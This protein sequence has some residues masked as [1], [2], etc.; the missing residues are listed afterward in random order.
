MQFRNLGR[1]LVAVA[2]LVGAN[3]TLP[4]RARAFDVFWLPTGSAN[5]NDINNWAD[6]EGGIPRG[7][8]P[9]GAFEDAA[10]INNGGTATLSTAVAEAPGG[11]TLGQAAANS[12]ALTISAGGVMTSIVGATVNGNVVVGQAGT[13][14]LNITGNG[15]LT[16]PGFSVG[17]NAA[18]Q[19]NFSGTANVS[20]TG[21]STIG[22]G[23]RIT[24]PGVNF[25]S[26]TSAT[27]QNTS[28][29]T[30]EVTSATSHS[31]VK[32]AGSVAL[33]GT[34]NVQFNGVTP[35]AG[36]YWNLVDAAAINGNF[37]NA[38]VGADLTIPGVPTPAFG[39]AYRLRRT[40]GGMNGQ[41][42]QVGLE[43]M[44][45]L[46]V[47]RDTGEITI[48]NPQGAAVTQLTGY[49]ITSPTGGSLLAGYKGISG[50]PAGNAGWE[51]APG[52]STT[53]LAEFKPTGAFDVSSAATSVS[54]GTAFSKTAVASKGLGVSGE[55]LVF[56]Y[57][58]FGGQV[59][60]GQ[61]EYIGTP[62]LNNISLIVNTTSGQ[63][64]LK[65]DTLQSLAIDG[66]SIVSTTGALSGA[67]WTTLASRP[68][69]FPNWQ[70]SPAATNALS[71]TNSVG[72]LTLTAGQSIPLG[73]IGNFSSAAAQAGLGLKFILGNEE[74]FRLGTISLT[75][76]GTGQAGDF[77]ADGDVDGRDFLVW[78]R[79]GSPAPLSSG[80]LAAW[81][82]NFGAGGAEASLAAVPEPGTFALAVV[83]STAFAIRR[84]KERTPHPHSS[85]TF[86]GDPARIF[87]GQQ[88]MI[89]K[90]LLTVFVLVLAVRSAA[91][92]TPSLGLKFAATDPDAATSSL[93]P[94]EV[95]GVYPAPN[96][97]NLSGPTGMD[98]SGHSYT[99]ATGGAVG[100]SAVV[101]WSSPNTW[102]S[103]TG[104]NA[105]P[106]GPNRKLTAGYLDTN[107]T[108]D[109]TGIASVTVTG[110]DAAVRTPKYDVFVYFVS[111]SGDNRGG[112][113]TINDGSGPIVK[114]GSTM[115]SPTDFVEDPGTD[116]NNSI[117][118]TFLRFSGL[119]GSSFTLTGN[120]TLTTPNG[121]RAPINAVQ[122]VAWTGDADNDG[123]ADINDYQV[124]R[125]N[126]EKATSGRFA[127]G[128]L[129]G[130][131]FVD[132]NDFRRWAN[133]APPAVVAS[134]NIP[135]P[136][137]V[138]MVFGAA[139]LV[140]RRAR[141][142]ACRRRPTG[143]VLAGAALSIALAGAPSGRAAVTMSFGTVAPTPGTHDQFQLLDDQEVPG[144][145][146]PGGGT[147][148]S[149]AFSDNNGPPGQ[150]FTTPASASGALP[151]FQLTAIWLKGGSQGDANYGGFGATTTWG[152]RISEINGIT[153]NP[154]KTVTGVPHVTGTVLGDEWF[155][156]TFTGDD[157]RTLQA[158]KQYAFDL[159][160]S[161]GYLGFDATGDDNSYTGGTA[162]NSGGGGARNFNGLNTGNLAN[163]GYDRTFLVGLT[164]S[165]LVG[166][167]DV[168]GD[169]DTDL[170]DYGF[171]KTNFFLAAGATR[172][173]GDLNGDGRVGLDDFAVWRNA[174]PAAVVASLTVPEPSCMAWGLGAALAGWRRRM[175]RRSSSFRI[176]GDR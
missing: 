79:G 157:L 72:P 36:T 43:R 150:I 83:V 113:Y 14:T 48:R 105:F 6:T 19:A 137:T 52:N 2:V 30:H 59:V 73:S 106:E 10:V 92:G 4:P 24:G 33:G 103:T 26:A 138:A 16:A 65:N 66:Y 109:P 175:R 74:T 111:D 8:L 37:A 130:D 27:F 159:F 115:A 100:S 81:R 168:D 114:Y 124:I 121:N 155:T 131:A 122:I 91:A 17:G 147:Y 126:L 169:G 67:G 156:W 148:N 136:S 84:R 1:R 57:H 64:T 12:G 50:A 133:V 161:A 102:R 7:Y 41:L 110:I 53:G 162:F 71:E 38:P 167:G 98:V 60:R 89:S 152:I 13:G 44:L 128:D 163:H 55:D 116:I 144:G 62:F 76:G 119:T 68:G 127:G 120:A 95:A 40:T 93:T 78:Q 164:P 11:I 69:S 45:T 21:A 170:I 3:V 173:Q 141:Q 154:I 70:A 42:L 118:G 117:D 132:L 104:N 99:N 97:N 135:E 90:P 134:V 142:L 77:D 158:S 20:I 149:Q 125:T 86:T 32:S 165:L 176:V 160:S 34:L 23:L 5:Y 75:T 82:S 112:G 107:D 151:A 143:V 87:H 139:L 108:A 35:A 129:T 49:Q 145:A 22:R 29:L 47:N 101:T 171:I 28:V 54:L 140:G 63:A 31:P 46:R 174:A 61:I 123:D 58:A 80:D 9:L 153:L 51:K 15:S 18:S 96:W 85:R 56:Q 146:T 88:I 94:T 25:S 39:S 172:S 166:P